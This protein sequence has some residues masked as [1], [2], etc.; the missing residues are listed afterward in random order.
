MPPTIDMCPLVQIRVMLQT[1]EIITLDLEEY[2]R[3]VVPAEVYPSWRMDAL[4][5]QAVLAR[6]YALAAIKKPRDPKRFDVYSNADDQVYNPAKF[7]PRTDRAIAE[8]CGIHLVDQNGQV[9]QSRYVKYCGRPLCPYCTGENG[10][11]GQIWDK[12]AC[13]FGLQELA[14]QSMNWREISKFYYDQSIK[15][16]DE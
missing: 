14:K 15:L 1:K 3:G 5:A 11:N 13:Q 9:F 6:S 10:Y 12:R 16:S 7:H 4:K 8:T 2:L